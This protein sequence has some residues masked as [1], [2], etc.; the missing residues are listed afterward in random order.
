LVAAAKEAGLFDLAL[1]Q[2][3]RGPCD[4]HTMNRAA[5]IMARSSPISLW[6]QNFAVLDGLWV[7]L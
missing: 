6:V 1:K 2:A 7:W 5:G 3:L 4:P